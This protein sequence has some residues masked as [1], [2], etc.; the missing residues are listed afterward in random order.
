MNKQTTLAL[1]SA[2]AQETRL[3]IFRLLVRAGTGGMAASTI[4]QRLEVPASTC[5]FHLKELRQGGVVTCCRNGRSL[6]YQVDFSAMQSV[7]GYLL[8]ACCTEVHEIDSV[9][10]M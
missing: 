4:S 8:D 3:E 9:E 6:R 5:S 10:V 7:L 1:L 2:L